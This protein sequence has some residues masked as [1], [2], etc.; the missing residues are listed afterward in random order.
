MGLPRVAW[1]A[2][3]HLWLQMGLL[4]VPLLSKWASQPKTLRSTPWMNHASLLPPPPPRIEQAVP[5]EAAIDEDDDLNDEFHVGFFDNND[6]EVPFEELIGMRGPLQNLLE[7]AL[8]VLVSNTVFLGIFCFVPFSVGRVFMMPDWIGL[9]KSLPLPAVLVD[10]ATINLN[11]FSSIRDQVTIIVGY[12]AV[13]T[14]GA[15]WAI[16]TV[17]LQDRYPHLAT[18]MMTQVLVV[19]DQ[20]YTFLKVSFLL[21]VELGVFPLFCGCWLDVC[22]LDL[23]KASLKGRIS[24][25]VESPLTSVLLHWMVG[26]LYMLYISLFISLLRE[27]MRP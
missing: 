1:Q 17:L 4:N 20:L 13:A 9:L 12:V 2:T 26:I 8:T 15:A 11:E 24:F 5:P 22:T 27:V 3:L 14:A 7:N 19:I 6:P 16:V 10:A 21:F 25:A 18:P 23:L